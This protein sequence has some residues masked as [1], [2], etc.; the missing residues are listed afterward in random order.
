MILT[1]DMYDEWEQNYHK[2]LEMIKELY[3]EAKRAP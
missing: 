3:L 1:C 2:A